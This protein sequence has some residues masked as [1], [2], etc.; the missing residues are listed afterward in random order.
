MG[1]SVGANE[2]TS[3]FQNRSRYKNTPLCFV[4]FKLGST[5]LLGYL[6]WG[7]QL[8][9]RYPVYVNGERECFGPHP[10]YFFLHI[11]GLFTRL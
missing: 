8:G 9:E 4:L 3:C 5:A 1:L 7:T 2:A 11:L 6:L 10:V